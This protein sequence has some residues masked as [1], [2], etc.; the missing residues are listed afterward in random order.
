MGFLFKEDWFI[1]E[2]FNGEGEP[3]KTVFHTKRLNALMA[4][5]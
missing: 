4:Q 5:G 2:R 3:V 1:A